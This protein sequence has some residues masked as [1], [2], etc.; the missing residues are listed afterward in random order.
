MN[1][2]MHAM[3][4]GVFKKAL[5]QLFSSWKKDRER[6]ARSFDTS[7]G[8]RAVWRAGH[9]PFTSRSSSPVISRR[10]HGASGRS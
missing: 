8:Q 1:I 4:H 7:C 5:T 9:A 3:S 6:Q 2:S 10:L